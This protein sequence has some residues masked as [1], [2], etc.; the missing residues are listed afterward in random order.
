MPPLEMVTS[1]MGTME[2]KIM[3]WY[4]CQQSIGIL[5]LGDASGDALLTMGEETGGRR[6]SVPVVVAGLQSPHEWRC[7]GRPLLVARR[8]V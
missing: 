4:L 3:N 5:K 1:L 8:P 6:A 2:C 7:R